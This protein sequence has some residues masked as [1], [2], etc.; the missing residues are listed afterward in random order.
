MLKAH[1]YCSP[2]Y[3]QLLGTKLTGPESTAGPA[4][5]NNE[6]IPLA[7]SSNTPLGFI[8]SLIGLWFIITDSVVVVNVEEETLEKMGPNSVWVVVVEFWLVFWM[9]FSSCITASIGSNRE[10]A[11]SRLW[12]VFTLWFRRV[13]TTAPKKLP[14]RLRGGLELCELALEVTRTS[15]SMNRGRLEAAR[16]CWTI[17]DEPVYCIGIVLWSLQTHEKLQRNLEV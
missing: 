5:P 10:M 9:E 17:T 1:S 6:L 2:R 13:E 12:L 14:N 8:V 3:Q 4:P 16:S 11:A 15:I 7:I